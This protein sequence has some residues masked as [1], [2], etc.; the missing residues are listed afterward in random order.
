MLMKAAKLA[1]GLIVFSVGCG[2]AAVPNERVTAATAAVR[3]A[4]VGGAPN[5]PGASLM[6][7]RA[8]DALAK[9]KALIA[10][11]KNE[12][13][14]FVLQRAEADA[15]LALFLAR[16]AFAKAEAQAAL[17]QV[18]AYKKQSSE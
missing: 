1:L 3:A 5:D 15:E 11:G 18:K 13:A 17:D 4:E 2:G 14:D 10:D 6:L 8:A 7:K 12:D 9:A 16:E